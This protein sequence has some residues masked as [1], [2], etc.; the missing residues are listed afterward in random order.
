MSNREIEFYSNKRDIVTK[1]LYY[2]DNKVP[3]K[4]KYA[5]YNE[6]LIDH[7]GNKRA[8]K[9]KLQRTKISFDKIIDRLTGADDYIN[10]LLDADMVSAKSFLKDPGEYAAK[11]TYTY[12]KNNTELSRI[13]SS[14]A[15][16]QA[17]INKLLNSGRK[18]I[19]TKKELEKFP[20]GSLVSYVTKDGLYRS[21]GF[22]RTIQDKYFALQGGNVVNP[23]SFSVQFNNISKMYIGSPVKLANRT[24]KKTKFEVKINGKVVYYA[25]SNYD[26]KRF[27]GTQKY[28]RMVKYEKDKAKR[29]KA[30]KEAKK[31]L[32][33]TNKILKK[34]KN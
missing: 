7:Y 22:L 33:E 13:N 1:L 15:L 3:P 2:M 24:D 32:K 27:M 18:E 23:I 4:G 20:L 19:T 29:E 28:K 34:K 17:K 11:N 31:L 5:T 10:D 12:D 30:E 25:K 14:P 6:K 21:G 9:K 16:V 26:A 8:V